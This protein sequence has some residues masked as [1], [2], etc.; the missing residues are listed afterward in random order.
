MPDFEALNSGRHALIVPEN[1]TD[2]AELRSLDA[3]GLRNY[4]EERV[5]P[6]GPHDSIRKLVRV[7]FGEERPVTADEAGSLLFMTGVQIDEP[8]ISHD[9]A[10]V[11]RKSSDEGVYPGRLTSVEGW[12]LASR[13]FR[14]RATKLQPSA[15]RVLVA[16]MGVD[17]GVLTDALS[18]KTV[19]IPADINRLVAS[20]HS[21]F[22]AYR[23]LAN[24]VASYMGPLDLP[25]FPAGPR[26]A[27]Q[28]EFALGRV[29]L[30]SKKGHAIHRKATV[31]QRSSMIDAMCFRYLDRPF[32]KAHLD[33]P[34]KPVSLLRQFCSGM[35][36]KTIAE[37]EQVAQPN[38]H[39]K[40]LLRAFR[41]SMTPHDLEQLEQFVAGK[42]DQ[43]ALVRSDPP[44]VIQW[45]QE[46]QER[47]ARQA[48]WRKQDRL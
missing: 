36:L 41:D 10:T 44:R 4:A 31:E 26:Q 28:L 24:E 16:G 43:P 8:H 6:E 21:R 13:M 14:L 48:A 11:L 18:I 20:I 47:N 39:I 38:H 35:L 25:E 40:L 15:A 2:V 9:L 29:L 33:D 46:L 37:N 45:R 12:R 23:G 17:H 22:P 5:D 27:T 7:A 30:T 34:E 1:A 19:S 42:I 32:I 3:E